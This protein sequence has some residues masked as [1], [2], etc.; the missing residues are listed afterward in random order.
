MGE[1]QA[2]LVEYQQALAEAL[3]QPRPERGTPSN[4]GAFPDR[5]ERLLTVAGTRESML[6]VYAL[7]ECRITSLVAA[8]N[9]QLGRV[10]PPS[11]QWI[12]ELELW[13]RLHA[14]W[15]S[16]V[17]DSLSESARSRL[18]R[19]TRT[20]TEQLPKVSWNSLFDSEEWVGNFSRASS[21]LMPGDT[22]GI[23]AQLDALAW[24]RQ[25][26]LHQFNPEWRHESATL[27][28]H[29]KSLRSRPLT[30]EVL[31]ALLLAEQRLDEATALLAAT[32]ESESGCLA[33]TASPEELQQRMTDM[34]AFDWL[35][36]LEALAT[37]WLEAI[38]GLFDSHLPPPDAVAS[39]RERWLS[40]ENPHAPLPAFRQARGEHGR[41]WQALVERCR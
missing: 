14:C 40:L 37:R 21:P 9:N 19:V 5:N 8:R 13:R 39:Y 16:N 41:H 2:K 12:Y 17:P 10:A 29:L 38:D 30:A 28:G 31:R 32:L 20:K 1:G 22:R 25:A 34:E 26:T 24:L 33:L 35:D 7:R 23:E 18:E 36:R 27:E 11:Q 6:N 15:H 3:G 4:I